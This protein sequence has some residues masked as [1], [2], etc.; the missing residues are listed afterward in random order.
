MTVYR[1]KTA[2]L[3]QPNERE[4]TMKIS[5]LM[6]AS[7]FALASSAMAAGTLWPDHGPDGNATQIA[8]GG[9][10]YGYNDSL[11][12]GTSTFEWPNG[13]DEFEAPGFDADG[14]LP[15]VLSLMNGFESPFA[16]MGVDMIKD[17]VGEVDLSAKTGFCATYAS[18]ASG[19]T[20]EVKSPA[21]GANNYDSY[22]MTMPNTSGAFTAMDLPFASMKQAGWGD[23]T[24]L[25]DVK[26]AV[27]AIAFKFSAAAGK[28]NQITIKQLGYAGEC[29]G[30]TGTATNHMTSL[31][32]MA[33]A[34]SSLKAILSGRAL[35]FSGLSKKSMQV[36]VIN[37]QGQV[38]SSSVLTSAKSTL[39]L[40]NLTSGV[41]IVRAVGADFNFSQKI[42]LE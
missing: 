37:L 16:A 9:Y 39:N 12:G 26:A 19:F 31:K 4:D 13:V 32:I 41:Y 11:N 24:A 33:T 30:A 23:V 2:S 14:S 20:F 8:T 5:T 25:D 36:Q 28:E 35:S 17:Q 27:S 1:C 34:G 10:F 42:V 21:Y 22:V 18:F 6:A 3:Q 40:S 7:A 29:D 15:M 38:F